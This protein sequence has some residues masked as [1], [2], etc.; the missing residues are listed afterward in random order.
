[1]GKLVK[2]LV[3]CNLDSQ[4]GG[5]TGFDKVSSCEET[6]TSND[7]PG[8]DDTGVQRMDAN[9]LTFGSARVEFYV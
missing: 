6:A 1:M 8:V 5:S 3:V 2:L 7:T 9:S 4:L